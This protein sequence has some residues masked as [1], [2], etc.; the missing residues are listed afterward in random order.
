[1]NSEPLSIDPSASSAP[2]AKVGWRA[3][4]ALFVLALVY[5]FSSIDRQLI[6]VL[7][8]PIKQEFHLSDGGL[9]LLTGLTFAISYALAGVP[10]GLLA[11][12]MS[13]TKLLSSLVA[14]W[15]GLTFFSGIAPSAGAFALA[16][17]GVGASEAGASP[18]SMSLITDY[19]PEERRGFALSLFYMSTPISIGITFALGAWLA[20]IFGWRATYFIAGVPGMMLALLILLTLREPERG[21]S[22]RIRVAKQA[23]SYRFADVVRTLFTVRPLIL[24]ALAGVCTVVAQAGIG[25]FLTPFFTRMHGLPLKEAGLAVGGT[26]APSGIA[27]IV[28]GGWAADRLVRHS[29]SAGIFGVGCAM[30]LAGPLVAAAMLSA[31]VGEARLFVAA[32]NFLNYCYYGATF[33][34]Y[35]SLAPAHMRGVM[36]SILAVAMTLGGYGLGPPFVGVASDIFASI[37]TADPLRWALVSAGGFFVLAGIFFVTA[38]RSIAR[39]APGDPESA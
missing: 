34:T 13:R 27:G 21:A 37:G 7:A 20:S 33:A 25:A 30:L 17:I 8:E 12:R 19:Y 26:L 10:L 32:F 16:R 35:L 22:D 39:M 36:G 18:A 5:L 15:S 9:G 6:S 24:L 38:A 23:Q 31:G 11:D 14:I 4:Y 3:H 28:I 2:Q 1:M 29:R